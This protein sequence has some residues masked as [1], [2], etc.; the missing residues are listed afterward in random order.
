MPFEV[1]EKHLVDSTGKLIHTWSRKLEPKGILIHGMSARNISKEKQYDLAFIREEIFIAFPLSAHYMIGRDGVIWKLIPT[2]RFAWHAGAS[3][4]RGYK[5]L[6][7]HFLSIELIGD[8]YH[9]YEEIQYEALAWLCQLLMREYE[10]STEMITTHA[11]VSNPKVRND[12]KLDP[13]APFDMVK[14]GHYIMRG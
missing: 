10:I 1:I 5:N 13:W 7:N 9:D 2:N 12:Y 11:I 3:E 4:F 14:A 8:E 6:N